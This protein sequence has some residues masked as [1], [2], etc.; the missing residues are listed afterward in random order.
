MK[1]SE[2]DKFADEYRVVAIDLSGHGGSDHRAAGV[3]VV[4]AVR[5]DP[6]QAVLEAGQSVP[7]ELGREHAAQPGR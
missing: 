2:F 7:G 4:Q 5:H 6:V 3:H 1:V